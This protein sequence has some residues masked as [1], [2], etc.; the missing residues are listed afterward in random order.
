MTG[1]ARDEYA[2]AYS[3]SRPIEAI[4]GL[5]IDTGARLKT[6]RAT[7]RMACSTAIGR[8]IRR[9]A[10]LVSRNYA[11]RRY[12]KPRTIGAAEEDGGGDCRGYH[13]RWPSP[14]H[15]N[16]CRGAE[17][18]GPASGEI[19]LRQARHS[20]VEAGGMNYCVGSFERGRRV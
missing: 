4:L 20:A 10:L 7:K 17:N 2:I 11:L 19:L 15:H 18:A 5:R 9:R 12:R 14:V 8:A 1:R 3:T 13:L 16:P 6:F